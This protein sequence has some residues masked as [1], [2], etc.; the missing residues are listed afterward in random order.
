ME[1]LKVNK[2]EEFAWD[3]CDHNFKK[4]KQWLQ[5]CANKWE[6]GWEAKITLYNV[7][8]MVDFLEKLQNKIDDTII[9]FFIGEKNDIKK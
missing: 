9:D 2:E 8:R 6:G 1:D 7:F 4:M 3:V 5:N